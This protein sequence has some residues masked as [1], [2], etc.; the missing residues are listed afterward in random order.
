M[1]DFIAVLIARRRWIL[2][3]WLGLCLVAAGLASQLSSEIV[4]GGEASSASQS[5]QVADAMSRAKTPS[6]FVAV[7]RA[8]TSVP[9]AVRGGQLARLTA[10]LLRI[11]GVIAVTPRDGAVP[12][13]SG[14]ASG[15]ASTS[16]AP[17]RSV[18][19]LFLSTSGGNN[20]AIE[21]AKRLS[22]LRSALASSGTTVY[23][24]GFG[25]YNNELVQQSQADLE[26]AERIGIP[27]VFLVLLL[28]F[29]SLWSAGL[30]LAIALSALLVGL[31]AVS[32]LGRVLSLSEYVTNA[33]SM[34]GI[35]LGVDYALFLV[36]R[37]RQLLQRDI[38][39]I[40]AIT[41]TMRT[42]GVA[43]LWSGAVVLTAEASLLLVDSRAI[44]SSAL[45]MVLVTLFAVLTA[46]II[47][48]ILLYLLRHRL[49]R[50]ARGKRRL[51]VG[52][53][54]RLGADWWERLAR[55]VVDQAPVWLAVSLI[56]MVAL[57]VP[58]RSLRQDVNV[59]SVASTLPAGSPVRKAYAL[60]DAQFGAGTIEPVVVAL[61][62]HG[63]IGE[64]PQAAV[65]S[66]R[67]VLAADP[68][69]AGVSVS[70]QAAGPTSPELLAIST[71]QGAYSAQAHELVTSL[72]S[73]ALHRRLSR[74]SYQVG[75]AT[76]TVIDVN[77]TVFNGL[78]PVFAVL[79]V[80]V[81]G[82]LGVAL[83]SVALAVKAGVLVVLS[84]AASLGGLILLTQ[85]AFGAR[86][87]GAGQPTSINPFVPITIVSLVMA[88]STDY[89][90][91]LISRIAEYYRQSTDNKASIVSGV[92]E[93][94]R[95]ITNAAIIMI[96][97]F[98]G[99]SL[100]A[101]PTLKQLGVGLAL[102]V[103][104]DA[105]VVRLIMV[106]STMS[107]LGRW[108]WW[109]PHRLQRYGVTA[110]RYDRSGGAHP[111]I[112]ADFVYAGVAEP[113]ETLHENCDGDKSRLTPKQ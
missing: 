31:G 18:A 71:R 16:P 60:A 58:A 90:V 61:Q 109:L 103:L 96:A 48:P 12:A 81:V 11:P 100:A 53:S 26:S 79:L 107:L 56:A 37:A 24:G 45:A 74:Y 3:A 25:A 46:T 105:S 33:S 72:R 21:V 98:A 86:L 42:T 38:E 102:A 110:H 32:L 47:G 39:P 93:T 77:T 36:Q 70:P 101:L 84:L 1:D 62:R 89:E 104:L 9:Q 10:W 4:P 65:S 8:P 63:T 111:A 5:S 43:V 7:D 57:A 30:P 15:S 82:V 22:A 106:P 112:V 13:G 78:L 91:I 59:S 87:I 50:P 94:G 64:S 73:G 75:G 19:F 67:E 83:R 23:V 95:V 51:D 49:V 6:L 20:G 40:A 28:S 54:G 69:V 2:G 108:N 88:L 17:S 97:V 99:F 76:A 85:T 14:V 29:G 68:R 92:A 41:Q 52:W 80:L 113:S 55:R 27:I 34:L 66:L 44:R 35:A